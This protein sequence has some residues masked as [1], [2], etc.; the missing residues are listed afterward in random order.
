[1]FSAFFHSFNS[2]PLDGLKAMHKFS[3]LPSFPICSLL[4][5]I[6]IPFVFLPEGCHA[7]G[8]LYL[9]SKNLSPSSICL[10]PII[11]AS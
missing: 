7:S 3:L 11:Q 1:M 5:L 8:F 9:E 4:F 10:L 2:V 6:A